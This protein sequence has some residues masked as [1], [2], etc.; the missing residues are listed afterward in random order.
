MFLRT[1]VAT[2]AVVVW[3]VLAGAS[4][5]I[6]SGTLPE[7]P[8]G[9]IDALTEEQFYVDGSATSARVFTFANG[10]RSL[11]FI[12]MIHQA[13]PAF[14]EAVAGE[15]KQL[16]AQGMDL[17]YEFIDFDD[18]TLENKRRVRAML[19]FLPSPAFYAENVS[20]GLVAQDNSKFLGFPGGRDVNVDLTP[21]ELADAYERLVGPLEIS[22]ENLTM[23]IG[24]FVM[25]TADVMQITSVTIDRRNQHLAEAINSASGSVLVLY[26]AAHGAG[27]VKELYALDPS[28]RR[29]D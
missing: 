25:P 14:Y 6:K 24:E 15:V 2:L 17:F 16:K 18:V 22:D 8:E 27:T 4:Q 20:G 9:D 3:A 11:H 23:P 5:H 7:G 29:V 1:C 21:A 19:G 12:P 13:E 10:S 26:G 28:W